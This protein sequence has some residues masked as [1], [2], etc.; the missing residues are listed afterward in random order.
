LM[1]DRTLGFWFVFV[2]VLHFAKGALF[3]RM[4]GC[5]PHWGPVRAEV[6]DAGGEL[7]T[8]QTQLE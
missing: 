1:V 5:Y 8:P 2:R 4:I 7:F 3:F 6:D